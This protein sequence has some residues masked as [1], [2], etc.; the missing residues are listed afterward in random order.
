MKN[1]RIYSSPEIEVTRF[2]FESILFDG[3]TDDVELQTIKQSDAEYKVNS[4]DD[5]DMG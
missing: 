3:G 1:K 5:G 2:S 4:G